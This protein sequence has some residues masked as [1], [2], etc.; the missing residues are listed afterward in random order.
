MRPSQGTCSRC[1]NIRGRGLSRSKASQMYQIWAW[2][3]T[4]M[5]IMATKATKVIMATTILTPHTTA[6]TTYKLRAPQTWISPTAT[7]PD[8]PQTWW[9]GSPQPSWGNNPAGRQHPSSP[10]C[11]VQLR[12]QIK[13]ISWRLCRNP[14][15]SKVIC[16]KDWKLWKRFE[17]F[18]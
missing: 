9:W 10:A 17:G 18:V 2:A 4:N 13:E 12:G 11:S 15:I 5:P 6:T 8:N 7:S 1:R 16:C 3:S 14:S